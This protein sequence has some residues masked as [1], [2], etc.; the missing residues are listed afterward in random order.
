MIINVLNTRRLTQMAQV[1]GKVK[2]FDPKLGYGFITD[3]QGTDVFVHH[4]EITKGRYVTLEE[5]DEVTF[6]VG[7]G[8]KK[9]S[10]EAKNV[11]LTKR[12]PSKPKK[13]ETEATEEAA[14]PAATETAE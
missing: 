8:K 7:E 10:V 1:H 14:T 6:E 9:G 2:W 11:I 4:S 5:S 12:A 13:K 3:D